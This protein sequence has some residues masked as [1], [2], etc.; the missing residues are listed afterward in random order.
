MKQ[1]IILLLLVPMLVT[2]AEWHVAPNANGDGTFENPWDLQTALYHPDQVQP[3]DI[4]WLHEGTYEGLF[5]SHL[6]GTIDNPIIV[7][8]YPNERAILDGKTNQGAILTVYGDDVW[9]WGFE[10]MSSSGDHT[11]QQSTSWPTDIEMPNGIVV[12]TNEYGTAKRT[13]FINLYIHDT[14]QGISLWTSAQDVEL[15]G[16]IIQNN[17]WSAP[18]RGHGHG[19]YTQNKQG[20]K[21][22]ENNIFLPGFS[23][24][25]I[26]AYGS[27]VSFLDNFHIKNNTAINVI[28]LIGG[29]DV[30]QNNVISSNDF[31]ASHFGVRVLYLGYHYI[32]GAGVS[33]TILT[34]NR[35]LG[36]IAI[37]PSRDGLQVTQNRFIGNFESFESN[38]WSEN[39][40]Y[41]EIWPNPPSNLPTK[42]EIIIKPNKYDTNRAHIVIYNWENKDT[43]DLDLS[44][45][46]D[47][48]TTYTIKNAANLDDPKITGIYSGT[49]SIPM[50]TWTLATPIGQTESLAQ[51]SYPQFGVFLLTTQQNTQLPMITLLN[52][53]LIKDT[54][55]LKASTM[56]DGALLRFL[57]DDEVFASVSS[58][59]SVQWD[60]TTYE[61]G[62]HQI[63][64]QYQ[65]EIVHSITVRTDNNPPQIL[66][67]TF[68]NSTLY[69]KTN[70]PANCKYSVTANTNYEN[71]SYSFVSNNDS[72]SLQ[73][74][75]SV[76]VRCKDLAGNVNNN[77]YY[78]ERT[79]EGDLNTD[80]V[81]NIQ[82]IMVLINY[83]TQDNTGISAVDMNDDGVLNILDMMVIVRLL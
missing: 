30:V 10:I 43:V 38:E 46:V 68:E 47:I 76:Y 5:Y 33:D 74:Q 60:T 24:Y 41:E 12:S 16:S 19:L 72:H 11:S 81:V 1:L 20:I 27:D 77:D 75:S 66:N 55:T 2:A 23:S 58:P 7:R 49:I 37:H 42:N 64:L 4:I 51:N 82:D 8:Q 54:I 28:N 13:K 80:G 67:Y 32:G 50:S 52:N 69:V 44:E 48:G 65:G 15:Y 6:S 61:D 9:Y 45:F 18:D 79:L 29:G 14:M 71:M 25:G 31:W 53:S 17:G 56:T 22:I 36:H 26:H 57:V 73:I 39:E 83:F 21:T 35:L 3:G 34:N 63:S 70:E 62:L 78:I 40:Y 59:Y